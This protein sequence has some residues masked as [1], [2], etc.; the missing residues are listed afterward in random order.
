MHSILPSRVQLFWRNKQLARFIRLSEKTSIHYLLISIQ[1][2][3]LLEEKATDKLVI[4]KPAMSHSLFSLI[5]CSLISIFYYLVTKFIMVVACASIFH[6]VLLT[7][8]LKY[9]GCIIIQIIYY[10]IPLV[11]H[12][13]IVYMPLGH[14][15]IKLFIET[16]ISVRSCPQ[17]LRC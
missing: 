8:L 16:C 7:W 10:Y 6:T 17:Y 3:L 9:D 1:G 15:I 5:I 4:K 11:L 13:L 12:K 14:A 2:L